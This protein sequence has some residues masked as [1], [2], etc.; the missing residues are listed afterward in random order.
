MNNGILNYDKNHVYWKGNKYKRVG[1][2]IV[3][4]GNKYRNGSSKLP[5]E[6][7]ANK[8]EKQIN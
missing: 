8:A 2:S 6:A 1:D 7:R 3:Y 5:W 4:N